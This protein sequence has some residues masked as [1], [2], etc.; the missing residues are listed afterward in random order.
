TD[1]LHWKHL[2]IALRD[3]YGVM[4][5]SGSAVVDARN[6]SGFGTADKPPLVAIFTGHSQERQTQDLAFSNDRG[7]TW[8]KYAGNPVL[9]VGEKDFRDPKVFWSEPTKRWVMVVS[10]ATQKRLQ[11]FG[12]TDLKKWTLLSEFVPA[13]APNKLNWEG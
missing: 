9:D 10:L 8:S 3:E 4:M 7:R 11:L 6:S 13:G 5:F 12:S 2:P 1:L